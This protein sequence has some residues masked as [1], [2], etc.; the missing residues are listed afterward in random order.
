[1]KSFNSPFFNNNKTSSSTTCKS[2]DCP[3]PM[4][5]KSKL[6]TKKGQLVERSSSPASSNIHSNPPTIENTKSNETMGQQNSRLE[7]DSQIIYS[8]HQNQHSNLPQLSS[9]STPTGEIPDS[10]PFHHSLPPVSPT[11]YHSPH[12]APIIPTSSSSSIT[13]PKGLIRSLSAKRR[14]SPKSKPDVDTSEI[15]H[16]QNN[17]LPPLPRV[18]GNN[19][20]ALKTLGQFDLKNS[21]KEFEA[22]VEKKELDAGIVSISRSNSPALAHTVRSET[23]ITSN[24]NSSLARGISNKQKRVSRI[25]SNGRNS[26]IPKLSNTPAYLRPEPTSPYKKSSGLLSSAASIHSSRV[27][28]KSAKRAEREWRAK[29][30]ALSSGFQPTSNTYVNTSPRAPSKLKSG[31]VPPKRTP[32]SQSTCAFS[33]SASSSASRSRSTTPLDDTVEVGTIVITPPHTAAIPFGTPLSSKSFETLGHYPNSSSFPAILDSPTPGSRT[34]EWNNEEPR[35]RKPSVPH[36][37]FSSVYSTIKDEQDGC[38]VRPISFASGQWLAP[39]QSS[40]LKVNINSTD[41]QDDETDLYTSS[42]VTSDDS[43][44]T[45]TFDPSHKDKLPPF[46]SFKSSPRMINTAILP[47]MDLPEKQDNFI[48]E[49]ERRHQ[50]L[51]SPPRLTAVQERRPSLH[52][53][54]L[55]IPSNPPTLP[56]L[57]FSTTPPSPG[58]ITPTNPI[59]STP[60]RILKK[61]EPSTPYS[62]TTAYILSASSPTIDQLAISTSFGSFIPSPEQP[63]RKAEIIEE[64]DSQMRSDTGAGPQTPIKKHS[65]TFGAKPSPGLTSNMSREVSQESTGGSSHIVPLRTHNRIFTEPFVDRPHLNNGNVIPRRKSSVDQFIPRQLPSTINSKS[66][67]SHSNALKPRQQ[68]LPYNIDKSIKTNVIGSSMIND[69]YPKEPGLKRLRGKIDLTPGMDNGCRPPKSGLPMADLERWLQN[70]SI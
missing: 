45:P 68:N 4:T 60:T 6:F 15:E 65:F 34:N 63:M 28:I 30:A 70:T 42:Q 66:N 50:S 61:E 57:T 5:F 12:S 31:P 40:P 67:Q 27:S 48:D 51:P 9:I 3:E 43:V 11:L 25:T 56:P 39:L 55:N 1:M 16:I 54:S 49:V 14:T 10:D 7:S 36:S 53:P 18:N 8:P 29:V 20:K 38:S 69:K 19:V 23:P 22:L 32:H 64:H 33:T 17:E 44:I 46:E 2:S 24:A 21:I 13:K 58:L 47:S 59:L 52:I 37:A 41:N 62:P 35:T 26:P